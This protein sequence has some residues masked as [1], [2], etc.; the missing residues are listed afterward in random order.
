MVQNVRLS[1]TVYKQVTSVQFNSIQFNFISTKTIHQ[2]SKQQKSYGGVSWK[3][4]KACKIAYPLK[5]KRNKYF[6][7][8]KLYATK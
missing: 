8:L 7:L 6:T 1:S 5:N 3:A 4:D 2:N